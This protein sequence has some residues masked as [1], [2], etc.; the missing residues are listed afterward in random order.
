MTL[1]IRVFILNYAVDSEFLDSIAIYEYKAIS[2][3]DQKN[4]ILVFADLTLLPYG[5]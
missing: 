4:L 5:V 2:S 1:M 3:L